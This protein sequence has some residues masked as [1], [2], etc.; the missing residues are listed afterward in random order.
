MGLTLLVVV[1][2]LHILM[3]IAWFGGYIFMDFVLWPMLLR[4]PP[5]EAQATFAALAP[6]TGRLMAASGSLVVLLGIVRGTVLG[7]IKSLDDLFA[8]PY[9][10]TWLIALLL[11]LVLTVWGAAL[12]DRLVGPLWTGDTLVPDA[13][14]RVR[15]STVFELTIFGLVLVCMVL[16]GVGM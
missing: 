16:M 6:A 1:Q 4:R 13:A 2:T 5:A 9:G 14:R 12:H 8:T 7:P 15:A 3:G 11:A 10:V